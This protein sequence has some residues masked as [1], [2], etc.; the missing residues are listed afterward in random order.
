[1]AGAGFRDLLLICLLN[2][3]QQKIVITFITV[4]VEVSCLL[5]Y[6][7]A[8]NLGAHTSQFGDGGHILY[9][10]RIRKNVT[11]TQR[12]EKPQRTENSITEATLVLWITG[13]R[14]PI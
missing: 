12:T 9:W 7:P 6:T 8:T 3:T 11:Y 4:H 2:L 10:S 14:G 1:M 13:L 5:R